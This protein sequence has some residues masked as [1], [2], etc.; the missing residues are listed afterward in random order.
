MNAHVV[1]DLSNGSAMVY[2]NGR[3]KGAWSG[4]TRRGC[5]AAIGRD[6]WVFT[7]GS[8]WMLT[9]PPDGFW[10]EVQRG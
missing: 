1:T 7:P 3:V 4:V 2:A 5:A 9:S 10:R 8:E 6:G